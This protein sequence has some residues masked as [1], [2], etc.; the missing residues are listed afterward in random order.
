[1]AVENELITEDAN[2]RDRKVF[3]MRIAS[4]L[5]TAIAA[6]VMGVNKQTKTVEI[7]IDGNGPTRTTL[8]FQ[9]QSALVFFLI[10]CV[11]AS[12]HNLTIILTDVY[13]KRFKPYD[14]GRYSAMTP[15]LDMMNVAGVSA[16]NAGATLMVVL[17]MDGN[18]HLGWNKIC[19]EF[20]K[21]CSYNMVAIAAS[22][23]GLTLLQVITVF[24][25][26][27]LRTKPKPNDILAIP[28]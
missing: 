25:I 14:K 21:Y 11:G 26:L 22:Y 6:L 10:S 4:C 2:P 3:V 1:M 5:A 7:G 16:A 24:S 12:M 9:D 17:A 18:S 23:I 20:G 27:K 19:D 15:I 8:K 13:R 28:P